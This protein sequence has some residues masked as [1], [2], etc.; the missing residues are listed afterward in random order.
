MEG[1]SCHEVNSTDL[2]HVFY[3]TKVQLRKSRD[4][5]STRPYRRWETLYA[6]ACWRIHHNPVHK[7]VLAP[8]GLLIR[9]EVHKYGSSDRRGNMEATIEE[10][11]R[12]LVDGACGGWSRGQFCSFHFHR[13]STRNRLK[14]SSAIA[15]GR[16][17]TLRRRSLYDHL[18]SFSGFSSSTVR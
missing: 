18:V 7:M 3:W 4:K 2:I 9:L 14:S 8:L 10:T 5:R 17:T 6:N 13:N 1:S 16:M 12:E 11:G 15:S